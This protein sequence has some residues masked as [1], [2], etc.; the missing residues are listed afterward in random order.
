MLFASE[1][2]MPGGEFFYTD[3]LTKAR[4]QILLTAA[5]ELW[6]D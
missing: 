2:L 4:F 1:P 3:R 6:S 5:G